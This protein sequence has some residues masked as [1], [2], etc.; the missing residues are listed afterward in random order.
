MNRQQIEEGYR[1]QIN[2]DFR[3]AVQALDK[4]AAVYEACADDLSINGK[5]GD[6]PDFQPAY[7][8]FERLSRQMVAIARM[9]RLAAD[10]A[11]QIIR[12]EEDADWPNGGRLLR[13]GG[14]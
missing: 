13:E 5:L 2:E 11:A 10:T 3:A 4:L 9:N 7:G 6:N 14:F 8:Q 12:E 1:Q